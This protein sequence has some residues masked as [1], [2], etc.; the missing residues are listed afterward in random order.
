MSTP[1]FLCLMQEPR[2]PSQQ[3][4]VVQ[5][6][7]LV[8]DR[9]GTLLNAGFAGSCLSRQRL[10]VQIA[11]ACAVGSSDI[12]AG[13]AGRQPPNAAQLLARRL[14]Q[15]DTLVAPIVLRKQLPFCSCWGVMDTGIGRRHEH[16]MRFSWSGLQASCHVCKHIAT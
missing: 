15:A 12:E 16:A 7:R 8:A 4:M 11:A 1:C 13:R 6:S 2:V 9:A 3:C 10:A 14:A 5:T